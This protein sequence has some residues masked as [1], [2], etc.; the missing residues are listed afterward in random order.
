MTSRERVWRAA[1]FRGPDRIPFN[2]YA[3]FPGAWKRHGQALADLLNEFPDDLGGRNYT[4]PEI[5]D[6]GELVEFRDGW[7]T[8]WVRRWDYTSGEVKQPA[9][10]DWKV[11]RDYRFPPEATREHFAAVAA[12]ATDPDTDYFVLGGGGSLFQHMLH[13]RG[14]EN[15]YVDLAED[16]PEVHELA[17]RLV[18]RYNREN[19]QY[20][21]A[22]VDALAFGDD[23]GSQRAL[24]ISPRMWRRFYKPRYRMLFAVARQRNRHVWFHTDGWTWDILEDLIEAGVTILNPQ[25]HLMGTARVGELIGGKVCVRSDLDRQYI[26][27]HGTPD[28]VRGHVEETIRAFGNFNGGLILHGEIG[29]DVPLEN[30]QAMYEAFRE[31]G[32]YPLQWLVAGG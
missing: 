19:E 15:L 21:E 28:D 14:P 18:A 5:A 32:Q 12:R 13:L 1:E 6:Q 31:Y 4:V 10:P 20:I 17:D 11:W 25:H 30:L 23:W 29:P 27:P 8:L 2:T 16:R 26:L 3:G 7:G 9:I 22:G 24:L